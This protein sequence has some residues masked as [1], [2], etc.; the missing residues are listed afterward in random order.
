[1]EEYIIHTT[2]YATLLFDVFGIIIVVYGG[3]KAMYALLVREFK[4]ENKKSRYDRLKKLRHDFGYSLVFGLEFFLA[5]DIIKTVVTPS[6]D[7][8]G[9]LG[10]LV[11]IR[12]I[13]SFFL[14]KEIDK[15]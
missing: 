13:L 6:W 1:M 15:N 10:A 14:N 11:V 3:G 2:K 7:D 4:S 12:S 8:L 9:K 5:G